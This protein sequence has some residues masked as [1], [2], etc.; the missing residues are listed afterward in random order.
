MN[1]DNLFWTRIVHLPTPLHL[2]NLHG[3]AF[4]NAANAFIN[5]A[6]DEQYKTELQPTPPRPSYRAKRRWRTR[7][8][9]TRS[10]DEFRAV[11]Q[12]DIGKKLHPQ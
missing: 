11:V 4:V 6:Y 8:D 9:K 10:V 12:A 7:P 2:Q 5:H 3:D 1:H